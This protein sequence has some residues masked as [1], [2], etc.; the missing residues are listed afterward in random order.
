MGPEVRCML[1]GD[2]IRSMSVHDFK[3][4]KCGAIS[5]DG[6]AEYLKIGYARDANFEILSNQD[7]PSGGK[8]L[9]NKRPEV[10]R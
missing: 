7:L 6:G 8:E 4:C 2:V 5:V 1:C 10:S 9:G 3:Y